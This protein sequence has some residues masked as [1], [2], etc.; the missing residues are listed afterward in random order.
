MGNSVGNL[1]DYW[2]TFEKY[3]SL[4]G[5]FIWDW[6]DQVIAKKDSNGVKYWA[7]G[8][9]F[10]N[11]FT[12]NDSN[13]CA[14]GLIAADRSLNPHIHEVKKVFQPIRFKSDNL[15]RGRVKVT[16]DFDFIDLSDYTFSWYIKGDN[17]I[18]ASGKLGTLDLEA[19]D[20]RTLTFNLSSIRPKEGIR[21]FL[22]VQAK[23]KFE[24]PLIPE[25]YLVAWDQFELPIYRESKPQ[26]PSKFTSINLS[27]NE[28][29]TEVSGE[30]FKVIF[31]HETGQLSQYV[32]SGV[33]LLT[34]S[35]KPNFWRAPNDNDLGNG[36]PART[37]I[38][39]EAHERFSSISIKTK[40]VNNTAEIKFVSIDSLSNS[41]LTSQYFIYGNGAVKINQ[42]LTVED[43]TI[44]E[45]PRFGI[46]I[47]MSGEFDQVS[48]YG[49]GPHE[50][51]WDRK[52]S[53]AIGHYSGSVWEQ[54]FPYVRPQETGNKTDIFWMAVSNGSY[55]LMAKGF[56][57]FDGSVHQYPYEDLDHIAGS[58]RHG[59]LDINQKDHLDWLID[60]KQMGVGGDNSWGARPHKKYT[61]FP[62]KH[63]LSIMLIPFDNQNNLSQLSKLK[64]Q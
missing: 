39:K 36:M 50:S 22:T 21:Y 52:T 19:G 17:K 38:W 11:E 18:V 28:F 5:G 20:T 56:P 26:D 59:L 42:M 29:D 63:K 24:K 46:K 45:I 32:R 1:I 12:E 54:S 61:I 27:K 41:L 31:D 9:D 10:G 8:G 64:F 37:K 35:I 23:T 2:E 33:P 53:A 44:S 4:Q 62:G 34:N 7:Y 16:N 58:Q 57:T 55:G 25:N 14:N 60:Y 3:K 6:V 43:S 47:S 15:K 49:R 30:G 48:W 51:Y 13:F 40:L